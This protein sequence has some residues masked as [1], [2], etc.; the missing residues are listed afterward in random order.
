MKHTYLDF[1]SFLLPL[2]LIAQLQSI[3]SL[4]LE[5]HCK[6][7]WITTILFLSRQPSSSWTCNAFL[8][9]S[10]AC[11]IYGLRSFARW[12]VR[13][14]ST[15]SHSFHRLEMEIPRRC[16]FSAGV[17][18]ATRGPRGPLVLR[19]PIFDDWLSHHSV[20]TDS[21]TLYLSSGLDDSLI[22]VHE[23]TFSRSFRS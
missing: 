4:T 12:L 10:Q 13:F 11:G 5:R 9:S 20:E 16:L 21:P 1:A 6:R 17:S 14:S 7:R 3:D 8:T 18:T 23:Y 2:L 22:A 15:T 19:R